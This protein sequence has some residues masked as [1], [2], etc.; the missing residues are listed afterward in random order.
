ME[1]SVLMASVIVTWRSVMA[2]CWLY[3]RSPSL[4]SGLLVYV[5]AV[6]LGLLRPPSASPG[7]GPVMVA[8]W[9]AALFQGVN[10]R[11]VSEVEQRHSH[12]LSCFLMKTQKQGVAVLKPFFHRMLCSVLFVD[13]LSFPGAS[14]KVNLFWGPTNGGCPSGPAHRKSKPE[15][16]CTYGNICQ[17]H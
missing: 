12:D 9:A 2:T 14:G 4:L 8:G 10:G 7:H 6:T 13:S 11:A 17:G 5:N 3:L 16:A 15:S 1:V